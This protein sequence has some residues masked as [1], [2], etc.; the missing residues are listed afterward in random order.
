[1]WNTKSN[2]SYRRL[3]V[4]SLDYVNIISYQ[5]KYLQD[6]NNGSIYTSRHLHKINLHYPQVIFN[7]LYKNESSQESGTLLQLHNLLNRRNVSR[8]ISGKFHAS[9]YFLSLVTTCHILAAAMHFFGMS[10][11]SDVPT[12]NAIPL[13]ILKKPTD[14]CHKIF[15]DRM[16][17]LVDHYIIATEYNSLLL[18][19][20]PSPLRT[21]PT[22]SV[23]TSPNPHADRVAAEHS[24]AHHSNSNTERG[25]YLPFFKD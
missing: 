6:Q 5:Q 12:L 20:L 11:R 16:S 7:R 19:Q 2:F 24:Y 1:M 18:A 25:N 15:N 14:V 22:L 9:L 17:R 21:V 8:N 23:T 3:R 10:S 13:E 4:P